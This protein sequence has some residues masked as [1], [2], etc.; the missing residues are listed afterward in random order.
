MVSTIQGR[1]HT[2]VFMEF[3][4]FCSVS[5]TEPAT[6]PLAVGFDLHG[7]RYR[8]DGLSGLWWRLRVALDKE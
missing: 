3:H 4:T 1:K 8:G 5:H 2:S 6:V 7:A